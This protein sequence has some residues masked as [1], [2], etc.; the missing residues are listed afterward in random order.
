MQIQHDRMKLILN[1]ILVI[2]IAAFLLSCEKDVN[3]SVSKTGEQGA[4]INSEAWEQ[5][6]PQ[7]VT[8][9]TYA[10][11]T[12]MGNTCAIDCSG[13]EAGYE[14]AEENDIGDPDDCHGN[15]DSF[16]EGCEAYAEE[17]QAELNSEE[18]D[19]EY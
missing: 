2:L 3:Q 8:R 17:R 5:Y 14:W 16:V 12:F 1:N 4:A 9:H 15:S 10:P 13:H 7:T 18:F 6:E 19:N 11:S